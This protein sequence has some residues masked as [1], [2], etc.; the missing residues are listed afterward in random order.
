MEVA[1][2]DHELS[3][4]VHGGNITSKTNLKD[5]IQP[6][7]ID[8]PI[9]ECCFL[10]REK[11]MPF[12][13]TVSSLVHDYSLQK[14]HIDEGGIVLL[15]GQTYLFECAFIKLPP[16]FRGSLSP[17]SS[18]GRVDLMVRGVY[19]DCG[20]YDTIDRD[21]E[22]RL[23][24]E[25]SPRSFNIKVFPSQT[26][27]QLMVFR[28]GNATE[29]PSLPLQLESHPPLI[30]DSHG[31]P[32]PL[33][34]HRNAVV[35]SLD[36]DQESVGF[37]AIPTSQVVIL[38]SIGSHD[39]EHFFRPVIHDQK[40]K[41]ITL[42]KDRFYILCTK[43]RVSIPTTLS[44]EMV[45]FSQHI[46]E[47]RAHYAGFFDPGFGF[48]GGTKGTV[49]VLEVR[50]HETVTVYDGQPICLM[51]FFLNSAVPNCPYGHAGNSY[52]NQSGPKLAKYFA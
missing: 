10:M 9:G 25:V 46:G 14:I 17:K 13:R 21:T 44:A 33:R 51:E 36:L 4:L 37:E 12:R 15:R 28:Q 23:W 45:P 3:E 18:I 1:L 20:L 39:K 19:D 29:I 49:G 27:S 8:I 50:P 32:L 40:A 30:Y 6:A 16:G 34:L 24:L 47:L 2:V 31:N 42:E 7:S 41:A 52:H 38:S 43:E 35:L 5:L 22:G 26:L 11:V 48:G